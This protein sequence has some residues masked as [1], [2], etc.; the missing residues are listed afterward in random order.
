MEVDIDHAVRPTSP[1]LRFIDRAMPLAASDRC[2][3][4]VN[5][6][7][8]PG[9]RWLLLDKTW[10]NGSS[11]FSTAHVSSYFLILTSACKIASTCDCEMND[12]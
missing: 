10:V 11:P 5:I 3:L 12:C 1:G 6:Q 2:T 9:W 4:M 7:S 8:L